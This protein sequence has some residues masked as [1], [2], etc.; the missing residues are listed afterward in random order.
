MANNIINLLYVNGNYLPT[1]VDLWNKGFNL[2]LKQPYYVYLDDVG[3]RDLIVVYIFVVV[4]KKR[5]SEEA[6][7]F[8]YL[9][10]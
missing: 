10:L 5:S 7:P 8:R 3:D 6:E 4:L 9:T 1:T 2:Y